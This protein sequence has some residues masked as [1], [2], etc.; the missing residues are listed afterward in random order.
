MLNID[1][2][3]PEVK[4][5]AQPASGLPLF[6]SS[7]SEEKQEKKN[8]LFSILALAVVTVLLMLAINTGVKLNEATI[9][10]SELKKEIQ[11][12]EKQGREY[13]SALE[14]KNDIVSFEKYAS[15]ELG[16]LKGQDAEEEQRDD[17]IE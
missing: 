2:K 15:E 8:V 13:R 3:S 6:S 14:K 17:K 7:D 4:E 5:A 12:L 11:T 10:V 9:R 16:M 1:K